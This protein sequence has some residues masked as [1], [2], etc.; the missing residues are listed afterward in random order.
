MWV[1]KDSAPELTEALYITISHAS[2]V[3]ICV[4]VVEFDLQLARI[5]TSYMAGGLRSREYIWRL[6]ILIKY[7]EHFAQPNEFKDSLW[8]AFFSV[9]FVDLVVSGTHC[10]NVELAQE[11]EVNFLRDFPISVEETGRVG[12]VLLGVIFPFLICD[13]TYEQ[14]LKETSK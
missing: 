10:G 8:T 6:K 2:P 7:L 5:V 9:Q 12:L 13:V 3:N 4:Y 1:P 11:Q 14:R